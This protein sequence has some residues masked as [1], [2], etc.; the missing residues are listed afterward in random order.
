MALAGVL[1]RRTE[2][3]VEPESIKSP[4]FVEDRD[5][6][7]PSNKVLASF[8]PLSELQVRIY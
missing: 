3:A 4:R 7:V 8:V 5:F 1:D 2:A 6:V